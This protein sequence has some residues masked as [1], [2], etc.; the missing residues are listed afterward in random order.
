PGTRV[1]D[2]KNTPMLRR[3]LTERG[4]MEAR[5]RGGCT[6]KCQRLLAQAIKRAR[7]MALLPYTAEHVR[8]SNV[9]AGRPRR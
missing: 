6:A 4:K 3:Y 9:P 1:V 7:H 5:R 2:Y 8:L